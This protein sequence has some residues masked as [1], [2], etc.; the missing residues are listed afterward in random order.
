MVRSY[1]SHPSIFYSLL[2][3]LRPS[4]SNEK[5]AGFTL[6]ELLIV[7]LIAGGIISGLLY[8]VVE[9][10][11]ADQR[12]ASRTQTQ[13]EMQ[14]ALDYV[15]AE[16][17]EA[18]YV[19][20][21]NCMSAAGTGNLGDADF[22]PGL[23]NHIPASL[24]PAN[25][26]YPVLAFWK[27]QPLPTT[28]R[29]ACDRGNAPPD[30]PCISGHSYALVVYALDDS[31]STTWDGLARIRR[32]SLTQ[33][34]TTGAAPGYAPTPGYVD[35]GAF[36]QQFRSWPFYRGETDTT[37]VNQQTG[38]PS[39]TPQVLVDFV[40]DRIR[41]TV[42][43]P[44]NYS[45]TADANVINNTANS[46]YGCVSDAAEVGENRDVILF[47]RGNA[48]GRPAIGITPDASAFLPT[49]ETR[50]LSRPVLSKAPV[51]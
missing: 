10:L 19:Y 28:V 4:P 6:I 17:R 13:Q 39:G 14:M 45:L 49:L 9:L 2:K 15:S 46:F 21:Q 22:C 33:F 43:C 40:D 47:I 37:P 8:L 44:A 50:V 30:T 1:S 26:N 29:E 34:Q 12:E 16:L 36:Q 20:D 24:T 41:D 48:Q 25:N 11:T 7:I 32:Y 31:N 42:Q 38:T 3:L 18:V 27:Q 23:Y 5:A 35:P 51:E